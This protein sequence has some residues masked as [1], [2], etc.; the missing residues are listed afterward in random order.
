MQELA[1]HI[2][3]QVQIGPVYKHP[4]GPDWSSHSI[5]R[6]AQLVRFRPS[7]QISGRP[8]LAQHMHIHADRAIRG[9]PQYAGKSGGPTMEEFPVVMGGP[10]VYGCG[11]H[12]VGVTDGPS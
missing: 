12:L 5:C 7:A 10:L 8:E 9:G 11:T 4:E 3:I 2:Q 1:W 6:S